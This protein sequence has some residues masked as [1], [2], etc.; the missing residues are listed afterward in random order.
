MLFTKVAIAAENH[1]DE[2]P[3]YATLMASSSDDL[4][5]TIGEAFGNTAAAQFLALWNAQDSA[6]VDYTIGVVTHDQ[7]KAN[8]ALTSAV[9]TEPQIGQLFVAWL[10][11]SQSTLVE[12]FNALP[13]MVKLFVDDSF[14]QHYALMYR[15]VDI[16]FV[17]AEGLGETI[18]PLVAAQFPDK[19]PGDVSSKSVERRALINNRLME[20]AYLETML[21]DALSAGRGEDAAQA[22]AAA[23]VSIDALGSFA[24]SNQAWQDRL[25]ALRQYASGNSA[26]A[27]NTLTSGFVHELSSPGGVSPD[28]V[29]A[30]VDATIHVV[31]DQRTKDYDGLPADDRAAATAMQPIADAI[32]AAA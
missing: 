7:G 24:R 29:A 2:Y 30:Q 25:A 5:Q 22:A 14:A 31:D 3:G 8:S 12:Q 21:T 17:Q 18:A 16:A 32:S 15:E 13:T 23:K 10:G 20:R 28:V 19:F 27:R 6:F 26:Q 4:A 11:N 9:A 1:S